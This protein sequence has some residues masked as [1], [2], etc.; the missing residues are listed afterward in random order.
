MADMSDFE[1]LREELGCWHFFY[2]WQRPHGA[3]KGKT[4]SQVDI[5]LSHI[6]PLTEEVCAVYEPSKEHIQLQ[7]YHDEIT[8]RKLKGTL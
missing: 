8:L 2:N 3:L 6:T 5:E 4:P 7:Y 1:Q